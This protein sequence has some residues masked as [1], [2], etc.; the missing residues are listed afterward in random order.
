MSSTNNDSEDDDPRVHSSGMSSSSAPPCGRRYELSKSELR[1]NNKPIMEKK[2]RARI[3]QC[4]NELKTLILDAL[5]KDPARHTKLEKADILEMTVRHLQSLHRGGAS[6]RHPPVPV[7][8]TGPTIEA[9]S[10][11]SA[12]LTAVVVQ[13]FQTGYQECAGEVNRFVGRLDGVDDD[14]KK[15]LMSHLDSC[16][17]KMRYV[18]ATAATPP[19]VHNYSLQQQQQIDPLA[20]AL[21]PSTAAGPLHL[22]PDI[23]LVPS[24]VPLPPPPQPPPPQP[25]GRLRTSAFTAVHGLSSSPPRTD[26]RSPYGVF[27]DEPAVSSTSSWAE[28]VAAA[29]AVTDKNPPLDFS[30][31]KPMA[32]AACTG[33]K[34]LGDI[35]VNVPTAVASSS[36][37]T[38][39][40]PGS[41]RVTPATNRPTAAPAA[42]PHDGPGTD[43][44]MWRPW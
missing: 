3:N 33:K 5:K 6:S 7:A 23:A 39:S 20:T 13:K 25:V 38:G 27:C 34:P 40:A 35:P 16:V 31:K 18:A 4:L 21:V 1:K 42:G 28:D 17:A 41:H 11:S 15:R 2:R 37:K 8:A 30:M 14:I 10:S 44:N 9:S 43:P 36:H 32:T 19:P 12:A 26:H 29:A 24:P 22:L